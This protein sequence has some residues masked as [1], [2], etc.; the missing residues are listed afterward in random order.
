MS[1][2]TRDGDLK[3]GVVQSIQRISSPHPPKKIHFSNLQSVG[4]S[5]QSS[6]GN[7]NQPTIMASMDPSSSSSGDEPMTQN[8]WPPRLQDTKTTKERNR[9]P[10]IGA[11]ERALKTATRLVWGLVGWLLATTACSI[12]FPC[13]FFFQD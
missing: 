7:R 11:W 8:K 4:T 10:A 9:H 1:G 6:G 12:P 2:R 3:R 13:V 5:I